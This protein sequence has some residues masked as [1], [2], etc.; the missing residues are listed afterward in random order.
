MLL[1]ES[2]GF[3]PIHLAT[4]AILSLC[5]LAVILY[6][7]KLYP[8]NMYPTILVNIFLLMSLLHVPLAQVVGYDLGCT[9]CNDLLLFARPLILVLLFGYLV[10]QSVLLKFYIFPF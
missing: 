8:F 7:L 4:I 3:I 5:Y 2:Y 6:L 9:K 10:F 1:T